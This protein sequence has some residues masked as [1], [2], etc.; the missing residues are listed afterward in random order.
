MVG[1]ESSPLSNEGTT[2]LCQSN[3]LKAVSV[4]MPGAVDD[5]SQQADNTSRSL[6]YAEAPPGLKRT[7]IS[8]S[9]DARLDDTVRSKDK[10]EA[11]DAN[12]D[13]GSYG[14]IP[15]HIWSR[16]KIGELGLL[17]TSIHDYE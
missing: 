7:E 15:P 8:V 5:R 11:E 4:P 14:F 16:Q 1:E 6:V 3:A 9:I 10:Q 17:G 12:S 13:S 2:A